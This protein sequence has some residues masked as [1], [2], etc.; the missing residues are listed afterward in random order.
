MRHAARADQN[1]PKTP[2][3]LKI[4]DVWGIRTAESEAALQKGDQAFSAMATRHL[5]VV[6]GHP[7]GF[8]AT[9]RTDSWWVGPALTLTVLLAFVVY[10]TWAAMQGKHYYVEPYL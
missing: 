9:M 6:G 7:R 5:P 10:T 4:L 3:S 2:K 8:A 1:Q